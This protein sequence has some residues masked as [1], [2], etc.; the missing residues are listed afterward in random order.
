MKHTL[1]QGLVFWLKETNK[2]WKEFK[3]LWYIPI[4]I[5]CYHGSK[6]GSGVAILQPCEW[7]LRINDGE[8]RHLV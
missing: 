1:K 3:A 5:S 6:P 2:I 4:A 8:Q 7:K